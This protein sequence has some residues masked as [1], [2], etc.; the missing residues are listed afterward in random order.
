MEK[1]VIPTVVYAELTPNPATM[2]FVANRMLIDEGVNLEFTTKQQAR[3]FSPLADDLFNFP[4]VKSVFISANF[5]T[6]TKSEGISWDL[7]NLQLREY[8]RDFLQSNEKAVT[9]LPEREELGQ[10]HAPRSVSASQA[11]PSE[12]DEEIIKYLDEYVRPAVEGDG[13]AIEF[14]SYDEGTVNLLLKGSCSGCP[15]ATVT[16]KQGIETMLK[17][18]MPD[19][20]KEVVAVEA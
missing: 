12:H 7:I 15:S 14:V 11:N 6:I 9:A 2:K 19:V 4:F 1:T 5:V 18:M 20:V 3:P 8:I 13:G 10:A 17:T 16:L